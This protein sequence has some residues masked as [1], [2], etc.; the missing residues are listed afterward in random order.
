[1][2]RATIVCEDWAPDLW[3]GVNGVPRRW[4]VTPKG[5]EVQSESRL[6][7][8]RWEKHATTAADIFTR[9]RDFIENAAEVT[10]VDVRTLVAMMANESAGGPDLERHEAHLKDW[11]IGLSQVLT[12]TARQVGV[13]MGFP[14]VTVDDAEAATYRMPMASVPGGG[15]LDEWRTFLR[16]PRNSIMIGAGVLAAFNE[17]H[18]LKNDPV[19]CYASYNAGAPY[20]SDRNEWGLRSTTHALD[21]FVNFHGDISAHLSDLA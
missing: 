20:F 1:M 11:S 17:Q 2:P 14:E 12:A 3:H 8:T 5:I 13:A 16:H 10:G 18:G 4:R 19:L 21:A 15:D 7:R 6:R 9:W